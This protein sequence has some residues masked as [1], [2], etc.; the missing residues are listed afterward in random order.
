MYTCAR[1]AHDS[2]SIDLQGLM[3]AA[4]GGTCTRP[5]GCTSSGPDAHMPNR[6]SFDEREKYDHS[7]HSARKKEPGDLKS[8]ADR[9]PATT[10]TN[11]V[12]NGARPGARRKESP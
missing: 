8:P 3:A 1:R 5:V 11:T 6:K 9:G 7:G 4:G 2:V 12:K 10:D